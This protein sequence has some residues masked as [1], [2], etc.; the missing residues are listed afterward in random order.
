MKSDLTTR[1]E[2]RYDTTPEQMHAMV[3]AALLWMYDHDV[4]TLT[5]TRNGT[6]AVVTIDGESTG[7]NLQARI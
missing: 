2:A 5:I 1:I 3:K 7:C 4:K 6:K